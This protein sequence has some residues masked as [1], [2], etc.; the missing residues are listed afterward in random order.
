MTRFS[1]QHLRVSRSAALM[2]AG[3]AFFIW[4][5]VC[6][7]PAW[8]QAAPLTDAER[9][10]IAD[11]IG[12][13]SRERPAQRQPSDCDDLQRRGRA[14]IAP[15][16][17]GRNSPDWN[18]VSE[19]RVFPMSSNEELADACRWNRSVR[20]SRRAPGITEIVNE[21]IHVLNRDAAYIVLNITE[22]IHWV[23]GRTTVRPIA[24]TQIWARRPSGWQRVHTHESWPAEGRDSTS[25]Q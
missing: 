12:Q 20:Q 16:V 11:T 1:H 19:G 3:V 17:G 2:K 6:A 23:D 18:I 24:I 9:A 8:S 14:A 4:F 22:T 25:S 21:R 5:F 10:A 13:L 7:G 15:G